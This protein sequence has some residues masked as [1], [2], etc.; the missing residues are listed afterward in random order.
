MPL[1]SPRRDL[2]G[3]EVV[4]TRM[5]HQASPLTQALLSFG[6]RVISA[7]TIEC[8]P[9][10]SP[11]A[12][13]YLQSGWVHIDEALT[14]LFDEQW[15]IF[16]SVN[17]VNAFFY[18][19]Q[20]P[21]HTRAKIPIF[22]RNSPIT[23][24]TLSSINPILFNDRVDRRPKVAC[25]G[26]ATAEALRSQGCPVDLIPERFVAEGLLEALTPMLKRGDRLL[27]PRALEA[28]PLLVDSLRALG[29]VLRVSPVY[30]TVQ[31]PLTPQVKSV[32][33]TPPD[34]SYR[35]RVLTFTS[36]S[37][38]T[39]FCAQWS[40]PQLN[41]IRDHSEVV[42]IGPIVAQ[43]ASNLGFSIRSIAQPHTIEGLVDAVIDS[44]R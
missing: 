29:A 38:V 10:P 31:A 9:P 5:A 21:A 33:L 3:T 8:A 42:V 27:L 1:T 34:S 26:S 36:S 17:A 43:T 41:L 24:Q 20:T 6:A 16:T 35:R 4:V 18:F 23:A 40:V 12:P 19:A 44:T 32:L 25:I 28:R 7:P 15:I 2:S 37:T 11:S 22:Y 39:Q 30:Q 14:Q 13:L